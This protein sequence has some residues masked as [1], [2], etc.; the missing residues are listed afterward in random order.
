VV[1][2]SRQ[3]PTFKSGIDLV[4]V[5]AV[6][7]DKK[8]RVVKDL[9][10]SDFQLFDGGKVRP[11][12]E[13]RP[14]AAPVSVALLFDASGSMQ[15]A[16]KIDE[17][18]AVAQHLLAWLQSGQDEVGIFSFDSALHELQPFTVHTNGDRDGVQ[19][20]MT[21]IEPYGMTSLHDAIAATS[22]L[23]ASRNNLHRAV[24]VLTDGVDNNSRLS[25]PEVSGIASSIDVPVYVVAVLSPLDHPGAKSAVNSERPLPVG[26]LADLA[27]WTGGELFLSSTPAHTSLAAREIVDELRHQY[28]IVFEPSGAAGWHALEVRTRRDNLVVRA[29]SGYI[30]GP[31]LKDSSS[32]Q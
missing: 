11:I 31:G 3:R 24:I 16:S 18:R 30:A 8:G 28:L 12:T 4:T 29:R 23:V 17:A 27:R 5:S 21:K 7:R 6:V 9:G 10:R 20:S 14:D 25:P 13:F 2:A 26:D 1:E 19:R 22:R 32:S 15:V